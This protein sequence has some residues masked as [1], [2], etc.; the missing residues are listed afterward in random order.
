MNIATSKIP[1]ISAYLLGHQG[2]AGMTNG[3]V[4]ALFMSNK[5]PLNPI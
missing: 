4:V 5:K 2:I 1:V 3:L